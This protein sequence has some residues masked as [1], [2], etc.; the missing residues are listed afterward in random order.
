MPNYRLHKMFL[1][2]LVSSSTFRMLL[3]RKVFFVT[4]SLKFATLS[5]PSLGKTQAK[6]MIRVRGISRALLKE[7]KWKDQGGGGEGRRNEGATTT[8]MQL[9]KLQNAFLH[10]LLL[11][12]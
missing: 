9:Q 1:S 7:I 10:Y 8:Q 4:I 11:Y 2:V 3:T 5:Q 12:I 6:L